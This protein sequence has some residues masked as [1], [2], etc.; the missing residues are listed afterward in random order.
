MVSQFEFFEA[1]EPRTRS[2]SFAGG[3]TQLW[4]GKKKP[5][6]ILEIY[7]VL[8]ILSSRLCSEAKSRDLVL[9]SAAAIF[10][11]NPRKDRDD[12]G[13]DGGVF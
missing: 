8:P 7:Y 9:G 2:R 12:A 4:S 10:K 11:S 13:F 1:A 6:K 3:M 5:I